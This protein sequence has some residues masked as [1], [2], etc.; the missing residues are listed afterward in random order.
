MRDQVPFAVST[1]LDRGGYAV[2]LAVVAYSLGLGRESDIFFAV[3]TVPTVLVAAIADAAGIIMLRAMAEAGEEDDAVRSRRIGEYGMVLTLAMAGAGGLLAILAH[4][5][6]WIVA[7]GL[8]G[9][10]H[11]RA[12]VLQRATALLLPLHGIGAVFAAIL[13]GRGRT[14]AGSMRPALSSLLAAGL[15]LLAVAAGTDSAEIFVAA[16]VFA[17]GTIT[18]GLGIALGPAPHGHRLLHRPALATITATLRG[19]L[20][21]GGG[22]LAPNAIVLMERSLASTLGAG[23]LSTISMARS[24]TVLLGALSASAA[25]GC[26]TLVLARQAPAT[27]VDIARTGRDMLLISLL[28]MIPIVAV[29]L[30][31]PQDVVAVLFERGRFTATETATVVALSMGFAVASVLFVIVVPLHR[32]MQLC[33]ADRQSML[34]AWAAFGV[35]GVLALAIGREAAWGMG[36][37]VASYVAAQIFWAAAL[38]IFLVRKVGMGILSLPCWRLGAVTL[39]TVVVLAAMPGLVPVEAGRLGGLVLNG[40]AALLTVGVGARL[41]GLYPVGSRE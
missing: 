8:E 33:H 10:A 35:Y 9:A 13:I 6:V 11:D 7:P 40:V 41:T 25:T 2:L 24:V 36:G 17:T 37:L 21:L 38:G 22:G 30:A 29:F 27:Q 18:A 1:V 3:I 26:F 16:L 20:H 34:V 5:L 4:P 15:A 31:C 19:L 28:I 14:W 23:A 39:A 32:T 12:V